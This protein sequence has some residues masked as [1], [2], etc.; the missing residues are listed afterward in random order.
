MTFLLPLQI[1]S[2]LVITTLLSILSSA[3]SFHIQQQ[4][5]Q[6]KQRYQRYWKNDHRS[7]S[8]TITIRLSSSLRPDD[9]DMNENDGRLGSNIGSFDL[10][11][12]SFDLLTLRSVRGDALLRYET[13]N[14]S[15]PL[16]IN[17]YGLLALSSFAYPT[18]SESVLLEPA[19][20]V[21]VIASSVVGFGGLGLFVR[22]CMSR[23]RQ[24]NRIE[25]ELNAGLLQ[26]KMASSNPFASSLYRM[27]PVLDLSSMK[28]GRG[29]MGRRI[30]V[31]SGTSDVLAETLEEFR[32][33]GRR[34]DQSRTIVVTIPTDGGDGGGDNTIFGIPVNEMIRSGCWLA[35][36]E[37]VNDWISYFG[38]L[39]SGDGN[40]EN[41]DDTRGRL[42]W[43]GL[44]E[45]GRSFSSGSGVDRASRPN[46]LELLGRKLGPF[47][48]L[49][50]DD[51]TLTFSSSLSS[52]S[53]EK[54]E[55][56]NGMTN[57]ERDVL[58]AQQCFYN[59][60]TNNDVSNDASR[61]RNEI[62][63]QRTVNVPEVDDVIAAGGRIDLWEKCLNDEDG[64]RPSGMVSSGRDVSIVSSHLAYTTCVEFPGGRS[65]GGMYDNDA[66][67]LAIQRWIKI[68]DDE[69]KEG[70]E[71]GKWALDLHRTVPWS[72][73]SGPAGGTLRCD[74]RGC[75]ALVAG[76][77]S[78][79][80]R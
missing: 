58:N 73:T 13:L 62:F 53:K 61:M 60:L 29:K 76:N 54:D 78:L 52:T 26:L 69:E 14:Q 21:G 43:F 56:E 64:S 28:G 57:D 1:V 38:D 3:T 48:M 20:L 11:R 17:L 67:L 18:L 39:V 70:G 10:T 75:I 77:I 2:I 4:Q 32:P 8:S 68:D 72:A 51:P 12:P 66:T 19:S 9:D 15:E 23:G 6:Q 59:T 40:N 46:V 65:G 27:M 25:R 34:L 41:N 50:I 80:G 24:L 44:N 5:Q 35:K 7:L 31:I 30:I 37:N 16:R 33:L 42:A 79:G 47:D 45:G 71:R 63:L 36:A 74:H 49:D 22:E 55:D